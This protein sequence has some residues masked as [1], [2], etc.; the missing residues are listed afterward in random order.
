MLELE[1]KEFVVKS[2]LEAIAFESEVLPNVE[3]SFFIYGSNCKEE[4]LKQAWGDI[5]SVKFLDFIK[6]IDITHPDLNN[7][8]SEEERKILLN[9]IKIQNFCF[10]EECYLNEHVSKLVSKDIRAK[11]WKFGNPMENMCQIR[12]MRYP[13]DRRA[14]RC[15]KAIRPVEMDSLLKK[16]ESFWANHPNGF[17]LYVRNNDMFS[18][19]VEKTKQKIEHYKK[20]GCLS[21]CEEITKSLN[22]FKKQ[23]NEDYLG[24]HRIN[25]TSASIVLAKVHGFI[26]TDKEIVF[27]SFNSSANY[28]PYIYPWNSV[29]EY[30]S[31]Q[32]KKIINRLEYFPA[33][34][35]KSIFDNIIILVPSIYTNKTE[36]KSIPNQKTYDWELVKAGCLHPVV[37]GERDDKCYFITYWN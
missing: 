30:A 13:E 24:F 37:L 9:A 31:D 23:L 5:E 14:A 12:M 19:D 16:G 8:F 22:V 4:I 2:S 21:L 17:K 1:E 15:K 36:V 27:G 34:S 29:E 18:G 25:L 10:K 33:C 6:H 20:L 11:L 32:M 28:K 3:K 35:N 26:R 7:I